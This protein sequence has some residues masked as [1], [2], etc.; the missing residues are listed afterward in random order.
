MPALMLRVNVIVFSGVLPITE[1]LPLVESDTPGLRQGR[2]R[3]V[4]YTAY[5]DGGEVFTRALSE[6]RGAAVGR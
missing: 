3:H 2:S 1:R 4:R 5:S 6:G